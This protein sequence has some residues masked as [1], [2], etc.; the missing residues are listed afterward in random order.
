MNPDSISTSSPTLS[1]NDPAN[2]EAQFAAEFDQIIAGIG[3][4]AMTV[5]LDEAMRMSTED[6]T[7]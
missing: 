4:A 2:A 5:V 7:T 6:L 3:S 1:A